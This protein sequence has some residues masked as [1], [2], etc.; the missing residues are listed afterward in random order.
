MRKSAAIFIAI[1][2]SVFANHS[3]AQM[4]AIPEVGELQS[5]YEEKVRLDVLRPHELVVADLN[6]KFATALERAQESAQKAGNLEDAFAIKTEKETV[7]SGKYMPPQDDA[8]TPA[9][10]KT[11]RSTYRAALAR[12]EL[13]RDKKLRPLKDAYARSLEALMLTMT[14]G[15]R[16]EEAMALKKMREDLLANTDAKGGV[17]RSGP[18]ATTDPS[19]KSFTNSLGMKFVPV[20][21]TGVLFCIHE[22][23]RQDYAAYVAENPGTDGSWKNQTREGIPVSDQ[24]DHPVVSVNLEDAKKFCSWLSKKEGKR[25]R[26]PTDREWSVAVGIGGEEKTTS[27][28]TPE[29][30]NQRV[31]DI[32]PWG[33]D[34]PPQTKDMAGNYA[35]SS[36]HEK[37]PKRPG[38]ETYTDG[39]ATT[40]P[41]MSFKSNKM[42]LYDM[43][44]N[45]W[46]LVS[47]WFSTDK[48][49]TV[50]RG[51]C[52]HD[53][54]RLFFLSS[55]RV[56]HPAE[57]RHNDG[58][59]R[60]VVE[61]D[62]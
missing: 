27:S 40:A 55:C 5:K 61:S 54:E 18:V 53:H 7:L 3:Y 6:A 13:D 17:S 44:G 56:H 9:S 33:G 20:K 47:D 49:E 34:F 36:T 25:Y 42:G 23:R 4:A 59:F 12:L 51:G 8:K 35:D 37:M 26:L 62:P 11:M 19:G 24:N 28:T 21:G 16:L 39:F 32:F 46:E 50:M 48:L 57:S 14:K 45:A 2:A 31:Q 1:A 41:V 43:G 58:G 29:M 15:G 30:L 10:L 52:W 22:T 60:C 38:I